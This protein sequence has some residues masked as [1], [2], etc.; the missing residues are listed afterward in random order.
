MDVQ[1]Y[2][3]ATNEYRKQI[4]DVM[5]DIGK[6]GFKSK[7]NLALEYFGIF[8]HMAELQAKDKGAF[9]RLFN[10]SALHVTTLIGEHEAQSRFLIGALMATEV[11]AD[12]GTSL[13]NMWDNIV[14]TEDNK[15][16]LNPDISG[17]HNALMNNVTKKVLA[18]SWEMHGTYHQFASNSLS[19]NAAASLLQ[20]FRKWYVPGID[21]RFGRE[22]MNEFSGEMRSGY[23]RG[24][25][26]HDGKKAKQ[27][28]SNLAEF[29]G[30]ARDEAKAE[31]IA[32]ELDWQYLSDV[33]KQAI[34][35]GR[36]EVSMMLV[37][38]VLGA[39][40]AMIYDDED[41]KKNA[42]GVDK[43]FMNNFAYQVV[44]LR[45]EMM[46]YFNP[47]DTLS[48]IQS[49]APS[50]S[51]VTS[52]LGVAYQLSKD[53]LMVMSGQGVDRYTNGKRSGDSKSFWKLFNQIPVL[54]QVYRFGNAEESL[55]A[56]TK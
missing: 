1:T 31:A 38:F 24:W 42:T 15:L 37:L 52:Y 30:K 36:V 19:M 8:D 48:M 56:L 54:R 25:F 46:S 35:R 18:A 22:H 20:Q 26:N 55:Q 6:R 49:P 23:L 5:G 28:F 29:F 13:G 11:F 47:Y 2:A 7:M 21:R 44:R 17:D 12:D 16:R 39:M 41:Y 4:T 14:I 33:Q 10:G 32:T 53:A 40:L 51:L 34:I 27:F 50:A 3:K 45:M 9:K 43:F